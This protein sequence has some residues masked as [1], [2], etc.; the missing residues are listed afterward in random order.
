MKYVFFSI[1]F[2]LL[3]SLIVS[4]MLEY[5]KTIISFLKK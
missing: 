2:G 5:R 4:I 1:L 3:I